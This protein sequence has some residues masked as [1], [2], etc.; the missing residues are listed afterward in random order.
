M[1]SF[2]GIETFEIRVMSVPFL[3]HAPGAEQLAERNDGAEQP[4]SR[5]AEKGRSSIGTRLRRQAAGR[6]S[7]GPLALTR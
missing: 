7:R 5:A 6:L 2:E 3:G 4:K 1:T